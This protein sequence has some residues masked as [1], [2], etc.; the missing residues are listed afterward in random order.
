VTRRVPPAAGACHSG[1]E[2][3]NHGAGLQIDPIDRLRRPVEDISGRA[4]TTDDRRELVNAE[5]RHDLRLDGGEARIRPR[6]Q[7]PLGWSLAAAS[8]RRSAHRSARCSAR[9]SAP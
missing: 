1:L 5:V 3:R 8:A 2:H 4:G 6:G 9:C 7:V